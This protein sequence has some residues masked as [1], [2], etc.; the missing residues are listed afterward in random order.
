VTIRLRFVHAE[1]ETETVQ[2]FYFEPDSTLQFEAGQY[3]GLTLPHPG[4]DERGISRSFTIA[5]AP[6]EPQLRVTTVVG[7]PSSTFKQALGNVRPGAIV[8]ASGPYGDF[9]RPD[10]NT[11]VVMIAGGVG[12]TP[13][14][15]MIGD[16][17]FRRLRCR[18]TLLYSNS[19]A[20]I[21]FRAFFDRLTP[22]WPEL[23]IAYTVSR[24]SDAWHGRTGRIDAQFIEQNVP[25]PLQAVYLVCGPSGMVDSVRTTLGLLGIP[26]DRIKNEAFPGYEAASTSAAL[27]AL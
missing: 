12:I 5:S 10:L 9:V 21:P 22:D 8:E 15:S 18:L 19:T 26:D 16:V 24:P 14:R 11:S 4:P 1:H 20:D 27:V 17:A 6:S 7:S 13:F 23:R 25:D 2:S 3:I